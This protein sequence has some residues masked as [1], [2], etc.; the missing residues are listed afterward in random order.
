[1]KLKLVEDKSL[2]EALVSIAYG[3]YDKH[4]QRVID[5]VE[6]SRLQLKGIV[7]DCEHPVKIGDIY[8]VETVENKTFL[9]TESKVLEN[10]EKLY[11]LE[12]LLQETSFVRISKSVLLNMNYLESVRPMHNYRLEAH[13]KNGEKQ[14][15]NRHYIQR[16]KTYLDL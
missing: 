14:V 2:K 12:K 10:K 11:K 4:I 1:M 13:L 15:I 6:E 7:D 8:Y 9:Y 5:V 3:V 16:V